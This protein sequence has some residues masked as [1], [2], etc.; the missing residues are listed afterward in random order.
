MFNFP[1]LHVR[2][3]LLNSPFLCRRDPHVQSV[4]ESHGKEEADTDDERFK[5]VVTKQRVFTQDG[6]QIL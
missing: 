4:V 3:S 6:P 5:G 2:V 1:R